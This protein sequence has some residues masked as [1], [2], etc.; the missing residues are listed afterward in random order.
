M[1]ASGDDPT[2]R[3]IVDIIITGCIPVLFNPLTLHS[4]YPFHL[5]EATAKAVSVFIPLR[6]IFTRRPNRV[7]I[8]VIDVLRDI[9]LSIIREKQKQLAL[10][11]P[12]IVYAAP[13]LYLLRGLSNLADDVRQDFSHVVLPNRWDPPFSD[14]ASLALDGMFSRAE[15]IKKGLPVLIPEKNISREQWDIIYNATIIR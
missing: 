9:P 11:A 2:R 15:H 12:R 4:Q 6:S 1:C 5:D 13:P 14:A 10:L 7:L 3:A 8:N